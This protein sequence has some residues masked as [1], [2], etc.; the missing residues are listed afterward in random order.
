M[1]SWTKLGIIAGDGD[2]PVRLAEHCRE[3]GIPVHV[4]RITGMSDARLAGWPGKEHAI[5]SFAARIQSLKADGVDAI[6]FAGYV[7][8][9]DFATL[10][11]DLRDALVLPRIIS[12]A[13]K[14]DEALLRAVTDE[15]RR[16]G[17]AILAAEDILDSLLAP[18]GL[19]GIHAPDDVAA[20]DIARATEVARQIG[21][22]DIGQGAVVARGLVL[23]VEAQEGTDLM[24]ARVAA[25]PVALRG[26]SSA[27][28]GVLVK[29]PKPQQERQIDLPTIGLATIE[30]AARAGLA[31]IAVQAGAAL[32]MDR[33]AVVR[34]ADEAGLFVL[35]MDTGDAPAATHPDPSDAT[36]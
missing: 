23:A 16:A 18:S 24:L 35:G 21:L 29:V 4:S 25:L 15:F 1:R 2:L 5:S 14:G 33:E 36:P 11:A 22:M 19:L 9:P 6:V 31:G 28:A 8:R 30:G 20:A 13:T 17:F 10:K 26:T 12:A 3:A 34:A 32:V 27:R 7:R